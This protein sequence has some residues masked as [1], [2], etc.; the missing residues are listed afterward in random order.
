MP[1]RPQKD[2]NEDIIRFI[3]AK[4]ERAR[5]DVA[6]SPPGGVCECGRE[7][8]GAG[9]G[10][11]TIREARIFRTLSITQHQNRRRNTKVGTMLIQK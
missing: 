5:M 2:L 1:I 11:R 8:E 4:K 7:M 10:A 3:S 9:L 6:K